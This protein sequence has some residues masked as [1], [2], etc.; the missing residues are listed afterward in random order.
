MKSTYVDPN[1]G[2][3]VCPVCGARN[4]FT[5]KRTA[6]AKWTGIATVGVGMAAMPKRLSCNGCGTNLKRGGGSAP[7]RSKTAPR[8]PAETVPRP[9]AETVPRPPAKPRID[10]PTGDWTGLAPV[11]DAAWDTL[12]ERVKK[13]GLSEKKKH[14][15]RWLVRVDDYATVALYNRSTASLRVKFTDADARERAL[16]IPGTTVAPKQWFYVDLPHAQYARW[17]ELVAIAVGQ[18][19]VEQE[20]ATEPVPVQQEPATEPHPVESPATTPPVGTIASELE[21]LEGLHAR[22]SLSDEEFA[23]AKAQVLAA[24]GTVGNAPSS[25]TAM[26]WDMLVRQAKS[27]HG[28]QDKKSLGMTFL[29]DER[30]RPFV[31]SRKDGGVSI[32]LGDAGARERA[33][34]LAG[35]RQTTLRKGGSTCPLPSLRSGRHYRTWQSRPVDTRVHAG[36]CGF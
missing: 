7:P 34:S 12:V 24:S 3:V 4:Q 22:G 35:A 17:E 31:A 9:P 20:P 11:G 32:Q 18:K 1:T 6:K 14:G 10:A 26:T 28:L 19:A 21:R 2:D 23:Q 8:P 15:Q 29:M 16:A 25:A 36:R 13:L 30:G 27:K 33:L 5:V